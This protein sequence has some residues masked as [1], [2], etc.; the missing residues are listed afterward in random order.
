MK[1]ELHQDRV[2]QKVKIQ[3]C[4]AVFCAA[5][6]LL[7]AQNL[8]A[9][10]LEQET[11]NWLV[12]AALDYSLVDTPADEFDGLNNNNARNY[13]GVDPFSDID[14]TLRGIN[15]TVG[16]LLRTGKIPTLASVDFTYRSGDL[17]GT[18]TY[19][20]GTFAEVVNSADVERSDLDL[21]VMYQWLGE[22]WQPYLGMGYLYYEK[23]MK[24]RFP[25][26]TPWFWI[27]NRGQVGTVGKELNGLT[28]GG[29]LGTNIARLAWLEI[30]AKAELFGI[31]GNGELTDD[32]EPG[33]QRVNGT[34]WGYMSK[35]TLMVNFPFTLGRNQGGVFVD[36]GY[37]Y[38][39]FDF[40]DA[41]GSSDKWHGP[42]GRIGAGLIF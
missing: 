27:T 21:K 16:R 33:V 30:K 14:G 31:Y 40:D 28:F 17:E 26:G 3:F 25:A 37:Q 23:E 11:P 10:V 32:R 19:H 4:L 8:H 6:S 7:A 42:Y 22:R 13:L 41:I 39:Q 18:I 20:Q 2:L 15:F 38:Q 29:G 35:A 36:L 9:T 34:N 1:S 24:D 12:K 5:G